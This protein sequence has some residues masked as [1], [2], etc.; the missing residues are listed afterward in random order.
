LGIEHWV[1]MKNLIIYLKT[2]ETC[3]LNCKHCFTNG[4]NGA[5]IY[6]NHVK[7]SDWIKRLKEFYEELEHIHFEF[8]GGE[9]F[10]ADLSSMQYVHDNCKELWKNQSWGITTNLT[11]KLTEDHIKFIRGPLGSRIGTSWD[12]DIRF[13]NPKQYDLWRKNVQTL[14]DLGVTIKLFISVTRG[15]IN[16]N[17]IDLLEWVRDLGVKE[18]SLERLTNNGS[19][20]QHPDIFPTNQE[21]DLWFLK[22]YH[23]MIEN[24]ARDWFDNEFM[25]NILMK[26]ENNFMGAGTFCRDCEE[27]IFTINADGTVAGCPNSAP[28]DHYGHIDQEIKDMIFSP[29]R[30]EIVSC[31]KNRDPRCYDCE[32]FEFCGGDCHQ[33]SWQDDVCG[34]P[35]S[36]MKLLK[37]NNKYKKI[38][39]IKEIS[40]VIDKPH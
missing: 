10:L 30:L 7:T 4:I 19:A 25:E 12:P 23:Q 31:E 16:M 37:N 15:T 5:K 33:L 39:K 13:A 6:W 3:N 11:F 14:I 26:F 18:M 21:Q 8:H 9:P 20:Q 32:V 17:P 34:A 38:I 1:E 24:N 22:M 40:N 2:T 28:E 35:K 29:K 27:K 36:L